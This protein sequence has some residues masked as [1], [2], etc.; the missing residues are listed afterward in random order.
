LSA[1]I[2]VLGD[3]SKLMCRTVMEGLREMGDDREQASQAHECDAFARLRRE[4]PTAG[5]GD[6]CGHRYQDENGHCDCAGRE[7]AV[8][9]SVC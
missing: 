6:R 9:G 8:N 5:S 7:E 3:R 1:I 4:E 2:F